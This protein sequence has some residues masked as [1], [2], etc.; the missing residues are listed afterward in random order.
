ME[1]P[2]IAL[3]LSR[4]QGQTQKFTAEIAEDA[5]VGRRMKITI[6]FLSALGELCGECMIR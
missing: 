5:E 1:I 6:S 3:I 4:A 2:L